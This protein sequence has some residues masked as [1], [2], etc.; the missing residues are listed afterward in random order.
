M[1]RSLSKTYFPIVPPEMGDV[2]NGG[3]RRPKSSFNDM[4]NYVRA[5]EAAGWVALTANSS[6]VGGRMLP[7][8]G[9]HG[10]TFTHS[11]EKTVEY[12][13][14]YPNVFTHY[15][16]CVYGKWLN[17]N[18]EFSVN[19]LQTVGGLTV[20]QSLAYGAGYV[21]IAGS[22]TE[23]VFD[24]IGALALPNTGNFV[25]EAKIQ[26]KVRKLAPLGGSQVADSG[27]NLYWD[28]IISMQVKFYRP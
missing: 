25:R 7:L 11:T 15:T 14:E 13:I 8:C 12:L 28:G 27:S 22:L 17:V 1:A 4:Y 6:N 10:R 18:H 26:L 2:L 24:V 5:S 19:L 3:E 20:D 9:D 23:R 21:A 16:L